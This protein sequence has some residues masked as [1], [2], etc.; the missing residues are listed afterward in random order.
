MQDFSSSAC[1]AM[2][3]GKAE[4]W[5]DARNNAKYRIKKMLDNKCWMIDNLAYGGG[6]SNGGSDFYGD[7]QALIFSTACGTSNYNSSPIST[8]IAATAWPNSSST[9]QVT[10]N[11]ITGTSSSPLNDR[12]GNS[13]VSTDG[14]LN[15]NVNSIAQ[16]TNSPTGSG[17]L[18]SEC[19]TYLYSWCTAAG[20]DGV[21][22]PTCAAAN[23]TSYGSGFVEQASGGPKSGIVGKPGGIGGESK[24]N[25][26]AANQN[27]VATTNGSICPA[28]W[29]LPAGRTGDGSATGTN[30][31]NEFAILNGAM[32]TVGQTLTPDISNTTSHRNNWLPAG[33]FSVVSLG[34]FS[35]DVGLSNQSNGGYYWSSSL[36]NTANA[37]LLG[38]SSTNILPGTS[39]INRRMGAAVRCVLN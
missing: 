8:C 5:T 6:T 34:Y 25:N 11:N 26:Q 21:T 10:T 13:I 2:P 3:M 32:Y 37:N 33:S 39:N 31:Y 36:F 29:R 7:A 27:G 9:R 38:F 20:L 15:D 22:S 35:I 12:M 28:G 19:L 18:R 24:G 4:I 17:D 14:N 30:D 1:A 23:D 16:C